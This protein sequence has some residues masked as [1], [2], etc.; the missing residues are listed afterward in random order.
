MKLNITETE[1]NI[2]HTLFKHVYCYGL[3]ISALS[4][5]HVPIGSVYPLLKKIEKKGFVVSNIENVCHED[6]FGPPRRY[7]KLTDKGLKIVYKY[8]ELYQLIEG[9]EL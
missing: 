6:F 9:K 4:I 3:Q 1:F 7:Y 2:M 8:I 5:I